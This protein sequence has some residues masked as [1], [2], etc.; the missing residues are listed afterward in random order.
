MTDIALRLYQLRGYKDT[1]PIHIEYCEHLTLDQ[2][3][4][5]LQ[6]ACDEQW[7]KLIVIYDTSSVSNKKI[8]SYKDIYDVT[9]FER[10]QL[11]LLMRGHRLLPRF[12]KLSAV[13]QQHLIRK[14]GK[15]N[16]PKL[17]VQDPM[18]MLY[19]FEIDEVVEISRKTG[20]YYRIVI[21]D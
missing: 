18:S 12:Q 15:I 13:E 17:S 1:D 21:D 6:Q 16:L 11:E 10:R 19:G 9:V 3:E 7:T 5:L 8:T 2:F 14:Y 20:I 4:D